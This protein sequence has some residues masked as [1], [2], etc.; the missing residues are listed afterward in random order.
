MVNV[1]IWIEAT[2]GGPAAA[3][4]S[5]GSVVGP[6]VRGCSLQGH[7]AVEQ[8]WR[9]PTTLLRQADPATLPGQRA[10]L[11]SYTQGNLDFENGV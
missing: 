10:F 1:R 5:T 11:T 9:M 6:R 8:Q 7:R 2:A 3:W 4:G